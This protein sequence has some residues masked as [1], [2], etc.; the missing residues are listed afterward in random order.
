MNYVIMIHG[1]PLSQLEEP[2]KE[3]EVSVRC[4]AGI[5]LAEQ[6]KTPE[7]LDAHL[8]C[9]GKRKPGKFVVLCKCSHHIDA[10]GERGGGL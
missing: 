6:G 7:A 5:Q 10:G 1:L 8:S 3:R 9:S 4:M 2:A